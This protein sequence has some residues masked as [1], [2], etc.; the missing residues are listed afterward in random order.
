[1]SQSCQGFQFQVIRWVLLILAKKT[2]IVA[3][4]ETQGKITGFNFGE[5]EI[6]G[7]D[8]YKTVTTIPYVQLKVP[9]TILDA[10]YV[11]THVSPK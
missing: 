1:M 8:D 10:L 11:L 7:E 3:V 9:D 2:G 5:A 6:Y 4:T